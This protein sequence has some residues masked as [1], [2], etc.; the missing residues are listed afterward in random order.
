MNTA[1]CE[2]HTPAT[3]TS[4]AATS[5]R[6]STRRRAS[7]SATART[8]SDTSASPEYCFSSEA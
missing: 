6:A 5:H 2:I 7:G 4:S 1:G 8:A 3:P